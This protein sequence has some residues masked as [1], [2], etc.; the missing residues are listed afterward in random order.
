MKNFDVIIAGAG[1]VGLASAYKLIEKKPELKICVIE[2][3][4]SV[5]KHQTGNNSGVI[6]SGIYYK[7]G[8]LKATNCR[9]G[10]KMLLDFCDENEIPYD[11]CGKVIVAMNEE[12]IPRLNNLFE[13]G[14]QNGLQGLKELS[15]EEV[16]EHEPH[17]NGVKG[18]RVP[19]TG[20][21]DYKVVS[22]KLAGLI[23]QK[24]VEIKFNERLNL[25]NDKNTVS[26]FTSD[27][28]HNNIEVIT[29]KDVYSCKLLIT[30]CGLQSDRVAKLNNK[31]LNIKTIPFRGEYYTIKKE[32][33]YLVNNLIYPV[34]DPQF[35]FLGVHFTRMINGKVEAGPNAVFAFMR[36]GY[37]KTDIDFGDLA[38]SL[39]WKGF[40]SVMLKYWKVGIGEFYRSYYKPAFVKALQKLLPEIQ[41]DD[42]EIGGAGIRA[43]AC[44]IK[45]NLVDDFL[46][47]ENE[48]VIH[49][50]NAPS[51]A[52]TSALSIGD[53][54]AEKIISKL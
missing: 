50:C 25:I 2:K 21:I 33:R 11:I 10:Y 14:Q 5:S 29:N 1:I 39:F 37:K 27:V 4:N 13:R 9:R 44:D 46:F 30:C 43:Q 54:I 24:G 18:I 15:A 42:L 20:I 12:E 34:P 17:V 8:S 38:D 22:E 31:N 35:P 49:V 19:E 16:K 3:E 6:H 36:E 53:T 48:K 26:R 45:G 41:G 40:L 47:V 51:P 28:S 52:A 7:P 23:Q 32:K